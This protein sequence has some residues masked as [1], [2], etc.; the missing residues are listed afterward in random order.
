[1]PPNRAAIPNSRNLATKY[2]CGRS[3]LSR[4]QWAHSSCR[5]SMLSWPPPRGTLWSTCS[6]R[7]GNSLRQ[8]LHRPSLL[9][10]QDVLVLAV[11]HLRVVETGSVPPQPLVLLMFEH[12][13]ESGMLV[14]RHNLANTAISRDS[15]STIETSSRAELD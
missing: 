7:N 10:E 6:T 8:P 11:V 4:L 14:G 13:T 15:F 2:S 1:M 5:S 12:S 9:A 3:P